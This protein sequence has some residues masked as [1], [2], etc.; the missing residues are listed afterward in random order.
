MSADRASVAV[1]AEP[2]RGPPGAV[3][4]DDHID[5]FGGV[6]GAVDGDAGVLVTFGSLLEAPGPDF[7]IVTP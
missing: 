2:A 5:H 3:R 1:A 6:R 7:A 4:G